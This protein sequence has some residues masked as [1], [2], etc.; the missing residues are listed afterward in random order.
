MHLSYVRAGPPI[1]GWGVSSNN[2]TMVFP[3]SAYAPVRYNPVTV[4]IKVKPRGS[5]KNDAMVQL[6]IWAAAQFNKLNAL[7]DEIVTIPIP[8][9]WMEGPEEGIYHF[10]EGDR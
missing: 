9:M 4:N 3:S 10:S 8:L 7:S 6:A 1:Q 2:S 5:G